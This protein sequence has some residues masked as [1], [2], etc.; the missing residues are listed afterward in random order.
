MSRKKSTH[1]TVPLTES[2][3]NCDFEEALCNLADDW[4][5]DFTWDRKDGP[6]SSDGPRADHSNGKG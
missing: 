3:V 6:V 2:P 1:I 4:Q 5:D